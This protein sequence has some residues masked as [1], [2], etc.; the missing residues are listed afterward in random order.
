MPDAGSS[1][2]AAACDSARVLNRQPGNGELEGAVRLGP[3]DAPTGE[4]PR[5]GGHRATKKPWDSGVRPAQDMPE[6][7]VILGA[8]PTPHPAHGA[9]GAG[10]TGL[11]PTAAVLRAT[12]PTGGVVCGTKGS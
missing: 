2:S 4:M 7:E 5:P 6:V 8:R 3:G 9:P 1:R 11:L 10:E 12:P